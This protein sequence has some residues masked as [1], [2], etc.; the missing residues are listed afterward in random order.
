MGAGGGIFS[1]DDAPM[2]GL[3]CRCGLAI[4]YDGRIYAGADGNIYC[5]NADCSLE[6]S[7]NTGRCTDAALDVDGSLFVADVTLGKLYRYQTE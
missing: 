6:W 1:P 5:F 4:G 7:A 3:E 2:D